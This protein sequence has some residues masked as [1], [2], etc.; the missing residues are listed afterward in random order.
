MNKPL[1]KLKFKIMKLFKVYKDI[2]IVNNELSSDLY[3]SNYT[4]RYFDI[5]KFEKPQLGY[6][7]YN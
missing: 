4:L 3:L 5:D 2:W 7:I 6:F 1:D